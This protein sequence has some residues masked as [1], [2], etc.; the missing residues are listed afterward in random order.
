M[1]GH[2]YFREPSSSRASYG[3]P[4]ASG[5]ATHTS[6]DGAAVMGFDG[7]Q[8]LLDLAAPLPEGVDGTWGV[9]F[10]E[11]RKIALSPYEL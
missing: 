8:I 6:L 2:P 1:T 10:I 3:L 7:T 9:L 11:H 5:S 4:R